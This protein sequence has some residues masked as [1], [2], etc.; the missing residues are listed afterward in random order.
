VTAQ[1][2]VRAKPDASSI[3]MFTVLNGEVR[4]CR[5]LVLG[6]GYQACGVTNAN[7][8]ILI[9]DVFQEYGHGLGWSGF[10]PS[11]CTVDNS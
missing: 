7:G 4:A 6:T 2:T 5:K 3:A 1:L 8:W 10:I 11:T 9:Q